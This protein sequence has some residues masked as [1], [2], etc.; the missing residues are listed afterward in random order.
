M[1][2]A[3][4]MVFELK[5]NCKFWILELFRIFICEIVENKLMIGKFDDL[6]FILDPDLLFWNELK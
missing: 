5:K 3:K 4:L 2:A 1:M 6:C